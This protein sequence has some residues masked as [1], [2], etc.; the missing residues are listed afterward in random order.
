PDL[1]GLWA[2]EYIGFDPPASGPAPITNTQRI[3][4][5]QSNLDF[6]VGDFANPMLKPAAAEAVKR[7]GE[8]ALSGAAA[9]DPYNQ[10]AP[11]QPPLILFQQEIQL[12]QLNDQ[13]VILYMHDHHVRR[14]RLNSQHPTSVTPSWSGDSIAR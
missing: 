3:P 4:T 1:S 11:L 7:H 14:A 10:C 9:P 8:I 13:I 5:G 6:L 12:I 2:R